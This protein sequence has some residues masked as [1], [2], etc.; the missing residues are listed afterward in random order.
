MVTPN[1]EPHAALLFSLG[2]TALGMRRAIAK[3]LAK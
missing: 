1:A 3:P 2:L